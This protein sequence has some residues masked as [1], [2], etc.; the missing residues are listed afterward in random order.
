MIGFAFFMFEGIG[1]LL[2]VMREA[3]KPEIYPMQT[4]GA[5]CLLCTLYVL[6]AFTCYYAWGS[7]L[8]ESVVTEML[9]P[10][11]TFVQIM[12][13]LF[14]LNLMISFPITVVPVFHA[15][16]AVIGKKE[17]GQQGE[18]AEENEHGGP[19][20]QTNAEGETRLQYW[21]INIMRSA[22]VF[23]T[24]LIVLLVY[25]KLDVFISVAGAVFGMANVLLLPAIAHLK[26][27]AQ[28]KF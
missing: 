8:T 25:E 22:V 28:T 15:L 16:E 13:L 3:E 6:F 4:L 10:D 9:P 7:D 2:P 27:M 24:V 18:L 19:E 1:C 5:L 26:L 14:C 20:S 23:I 12:K 11:N 17:T 21:L